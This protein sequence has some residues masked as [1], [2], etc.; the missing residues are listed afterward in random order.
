LTAVNLLLVSVPCSRP[1]HAAQPLSWRAALHLMWDTLYNLLHGLKLCGVSSFASRFDVFS[2]F[3]F[4]FLSLCFDSSV[5][6]STI[7]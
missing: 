3:D 6:I 7:T 5:S 1:G 2:D 4:F